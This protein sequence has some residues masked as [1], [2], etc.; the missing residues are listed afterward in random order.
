[1]AK[2]SITKGWIKFASLIAKFSRQQ[3]NVQVE[4]KKLASSVS[5]TN[6]GQFLLMQFEMAKITQMGDSISNLIAQVNSM[7]NNAIRNQKAQ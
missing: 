5:G 4:L 2:V 7:I 3:S 6:P 1:M